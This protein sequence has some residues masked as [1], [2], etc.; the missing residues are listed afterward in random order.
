MLVFFAKGIFFGVKLRKKKIR[1]SLQGIGMSI[2][3]V[4]P[5]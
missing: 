2:D 4:I 1:K 5:F 3:M